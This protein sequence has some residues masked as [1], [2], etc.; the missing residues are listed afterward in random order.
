VRGWNRIVVFET[1]AI[2]L[3]FAGRI[4]NYLCEL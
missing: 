2:P 4:G 3:R 1:V